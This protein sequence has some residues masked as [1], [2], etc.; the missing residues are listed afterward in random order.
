MSR[1][2]DIQ[3]AVVMMRLDDTASLGRSDRQMQE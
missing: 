3:D 1:G 2:L